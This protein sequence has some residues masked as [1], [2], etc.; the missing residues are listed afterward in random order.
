MR[1]TCPVSARDTITLF[2][3]GDVMI[4]RGIDQILAAPVD[5]RLDEPYVRDAREYVRLAERASGPIPRGVGP[6]YVWGALTGELACSAPDARVV[7][8][9]TS[10]TRRGTPWPAKE[11]RYRA[12][13]ESAVCLRTARIDVCTL[14]NN[15]VLDYGLE[16]F[17][18]T[19]ATLRALG[20]ASAGAGEDLESARAP[21]RVAL[22]GGGD[23]VVLAIG[24]EDAGVP[25][26]WRA[27]AD[28]PGV[29]LL[30]DFSSRSIDALCARVAALDRPGDL[31]VVSIH[32]GSNWGYDVPEEHA[33]LAHRV[34]EAGADVVHGHS[35]HHPRPIEV[36]RGRP[37][38]YGCGD[39]LND[40]EGIEGGH[41]HYRSELTLAY[42]LTL[43]RAS[44]AL[45]ALEMQP[46]RV[47]RMQ[48]AAASDADAA[49]LA[50]TL[51][52]E[53][54]R[55]GARVEIAGT[56]LRLRW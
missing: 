33:L 50:S 18:D 7:N 22:P 13:P 45:R 17:A 54:A 16:G 14:A 19:L 35:S 28:R 15:H 26:S 11:V 49:W 47:H 1:R 6:E 56:R 20:I 31:V 9:E 21:A 3:S 39:L 55:W 12:S 27:R 41:A 46:L 44:G 10:L 2:L 52:R 42:W 43:D 8:L 34:I 38:L 4:G 5:P 40:Y 25:F 53:C 36:W 37:V 24:S 32:W 29:D 30:E 23:L 48:L 51:D